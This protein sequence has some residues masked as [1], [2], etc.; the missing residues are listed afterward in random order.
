[1]IG[2][3]ESFDDPQSLEIFIRHSQYFA[4]P[5]E[6]L[7]CLALITSER[8][9]TS[10]SLSIQTDWVP[11]GF[12]VQFRR[13]PVSNTFMAGV[14]LD[15]KDIT[16]L[17]HI[18][19][20]SHETSFPEN[21]AVELAFRRLAFAPQRERTE[22]RLIDVFIAAEALYLTDDAD[23]QD[24]WRVGGATSVVPWRLATARV[25]ATVV[26]RS[27]AS[28]MTRSGAFK[29]GGWGSARSANA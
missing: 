19:T 8:I 24:H 4:E 18:W 16:E 9:E 7:Q 22:D 5:D 12:G 11:T 6:L 13:R 25:S 29:R 26:V 2:H 20:L 21:K 1:M 27:G 23:P 14:Q 10:G 3:E 28:T 15:G 17:Q